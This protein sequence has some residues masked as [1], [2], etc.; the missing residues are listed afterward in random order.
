MDDNVSLS[1]PACEVTSI[2]KRDRSKGRSYENVFNPPQSMKGCPLNQAYIIHEDGFNAF[3][4]KTRSI[5]TI[6]IAS[7]C[8]NKEE[9]SRG[10]S[11]QVYSFVPTCYIEEGIVHKMDAFFKPLI[12][13]VKKYYIQGIPV[14]VNENLQVGTSTCTI[15]EGTYRVRLL[16]YVE[17]QISKHMEN[18]H[19]TVR[20]IKTFSIL[21][22]ILYGKEQAKFQLVPEVT[23]F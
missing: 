13:D 22:L 19:Y 16:V 11:V 18:L 7:A 14:S 9:R 21:G 12:D 8:I 17:W 4:K 23:N 3:T 15:D 1:L 20:V 6:Q 5:A 2:R 10:E